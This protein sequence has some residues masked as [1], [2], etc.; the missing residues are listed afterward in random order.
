MSLKGKNKYLFSYSN[1]QLENKKFLY[2]DFEKSKSYNSKFKE[3]D[4]VGTSFRAAQF[5]YCTFIDCVFEE[6]DFIGTNLRGSRF[7]NCSFTNCLFQSTNCNK[8]QFK[9]CLYT[10]CYLDGN[11]SSVFQSS[12]EFTTINIKEN[13]IN[14]LPELL[15]EIENLRTNDYIRR[16]HTLHSKQKKIN[17][18][19]LFILLEEYTQ[20]ELIELL[21][22]ISKYIDREFFTISYLKKLL[23][24]ALNRVTI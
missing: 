24:K 16:S 20:E 9:N 3:V 8:T 12:T 13:P 1:K 23:K 21:P 6:S 10:H 14:I 19:T 17:Y 11:K 22:H 18:T 2:K 4:F 7:I 5:K 15:K